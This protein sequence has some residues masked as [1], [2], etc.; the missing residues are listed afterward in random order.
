MSARTLALSSGAVAVRTGTLEIPPE[1]GV[2]PY[3]EA[4]SAPALEHLLLTVCEAHAAS[5]K[6]SVLHA[7]REGPVWRI[8]GEREGVPVAITIDAGPEIPGVTF[9]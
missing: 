6:G 5:G 8:T 9:G 2:F 3:A 7:A 4:E 1:K